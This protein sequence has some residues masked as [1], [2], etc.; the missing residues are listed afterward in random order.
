MKKQNGRIEERSGARRRDRAALSSSSPPTPTRARADYRRRRF[1]PLVRRARRQRLQSPRNVHFADA[2][3]LNTSCLPEEQ[4][5][6]FFCCFDRR[7]DDAKRCAR[8][9]WSDRSN[10]KRVSGGVFILL[11]Y[12]HSVFRVR[13]LLVALRRGRRL[14]YLRA[15]W[16]AAICRCTFFFGRALQAANKQAS[17]K[18]SER[19]LQRRCVREARNERRGCIKFADRRLQPLVCRRFNALDG[20]R[21]R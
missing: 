1:A 11:V 21:R 13:S 8:R 12:A 3:A 16:L 2:S 7:F 6:G 4:T 20:R 5:F 17:K 18:A 9:V 14:D 19:R 15:R 10:E